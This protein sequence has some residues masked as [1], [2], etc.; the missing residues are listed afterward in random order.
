MA[1]FCSAGLILI[2]F[3][4]VSFGS[5][6]NKKNSQFNFDFFHTALALMISL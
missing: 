6:F 5:I 4:V 1:I 2:V 3:K